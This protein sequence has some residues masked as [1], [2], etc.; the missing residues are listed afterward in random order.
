MARPPRLERGTLCLE[1][2]EDGARALYLQ[3]YY[4]VFLRKST[5]AAR[6]TPC[7]KAMSWSKNGLKSRPEQSCHLH[8]FS[9]VRGPKDEHSP[10]PNKPAAL[11]GSRAIR[12]SCTIRSKAQP[13]DAMHG[14]KNICGENRNQR[15][16][17]A[18]ARDTP[19]PGSQQPCAAEDFGR[20]RLRLGRDRHPP[21]VDLAHRVG[22]ADTDNADSERCGATNVC[23]LR[24]WLR[25]NDRR[26]VGGGY[27]QHPLIKCSNTCAEVSPWL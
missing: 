2:K 12:T 24:L 8:K 5:P 27:I 10:L 18:P 19:G 17:Q 11:K 21:R 25:E 26:R 1:G 3:G 7:A 16:E 20:R 14:G 4:S 13:H 9:A 6:C 15:C 23:R 22:D